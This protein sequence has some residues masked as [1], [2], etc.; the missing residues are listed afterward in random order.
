MRSAEKNLIHIDWFCSYYTILRLD[1]RVAVNDVKK[2]SER[3]SAKCKKCGTE[4]YHKAKQCR[5]C[6][7]YDPV[8]LS[9]KINNQGNVG[10][11]SGLLVIGAVFFS[12]YFMSSCFTKPH[13]GIDESDPEFKRSMAWQMAQGF[14]KEQLVS[15]G[16]ADFGFLE[17]SYT[18]SVTDLGDHRYIV[19]G[20][21][22]SQNRL[23]AVLRSKFKCRLKFKGNDLWTCEDIQIME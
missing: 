22:D 16:T 2:A 17:Q 10:F 12:A 6:G 9:Q 11:L 8:V 14:V 21:V 13:L 5:A 20:W 1:W 7:Q 3:I 19:E 23:G 18:D 15:P 4:V